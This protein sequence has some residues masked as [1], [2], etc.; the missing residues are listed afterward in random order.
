MNW[1]LIGWSVLVAFMS[2]VSY[3]AQ[4]SSGPPAKDVAY[5]WSSSILGAVQYALIFGI[6]MLLTR[7][8]DRRRFLALR[9]P[10]TSWRRAAGIGAVVI[11][12]VFVV[13]AVV[14]QFA[15]AEREQGLIPEHWNPSRIAPFAAF[16]VVVV[17]IA[18]IVEELLFRGVG[19]GLLARFGE[20][21]AIILVGLSFALV[22]GLIAGFAVI[23][24]FGAGLAYLRAKADSIYPCM[25]LHASFNA[26]GLAIGI[27]TGG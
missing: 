8:L 14:A 17:V 24:S 18:P 7:G 10:R 1:R 2:A 9:R 23:A 15:N 12:V 26:F 25:L 6:I 4:L 27:A 21:T 20:Y 13:S 22:H 16:C 3:A 19:Y 5:Q 11:L